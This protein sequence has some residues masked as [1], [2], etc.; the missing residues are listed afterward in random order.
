MTR[1]DYEKHNLNWKI[2]I[3]LL[4]TIIIMIMRTCQGS[5]SKDGELSLFPLEGLREPEK[6]PTMKSESVMRTMLK[7]VRIG[8]PKLAEPE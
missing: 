3:S 7:L 2:Y 4:R 8:K 5:H 6:G 1:R